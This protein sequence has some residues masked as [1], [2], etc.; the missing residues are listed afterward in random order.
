[1]ATDTA[2]TV[3]VERREVVKKLDCLLTEA[4]VLKYGKSLA[5]INSQIDSAEVHKKSVVKELDSDIASLEAQRS[6]IVEKV[7]RGAEY[8]DVK[9]VTVRDYETRLY[10]EERQD[11]GEI[12]NERP[13]RDDERQPSLPGAGNGK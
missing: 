8:R 5:Q 6:S 2:A 1:M 12:I 3:K 10:H 4:E 13:L 11:T 9:V 7:N